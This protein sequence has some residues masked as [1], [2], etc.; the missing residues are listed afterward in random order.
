MRANAPVPFSRNPHKNPQLQ[1][2]NSEI[3]I[4]PKLLTPK[5]QNARDP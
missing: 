4:N 2:Q 1:T 5:V 3:P